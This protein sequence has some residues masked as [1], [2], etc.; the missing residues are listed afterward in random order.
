MVTRKGESQPTVWQEKREASYEALVRSAMRCFYERGYTL[1]RVEDIVGSTGYTSGAFYFHFKNKADCFWHV[2]DYRQRRRRGWDAF[3]DGIDPSSV[4][5]Q[6][7]LSRAQAG[8]A[9][10]EGLSGWTIVMVEHFQ[11][12]REDPR[13]AER[14]A[15]LF[16]GWQRTQTAFVQRLQ[17]RGWVHPS[18]DAKMVALQLL[19]FVEGLAVHSIVFGIEPKAARAA[20]VDGTARLLQAG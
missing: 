14:F 18:R 4:S 6:E 8:L 5:L 19:S 1:T 17:D 10:D 12:H 7:V 20:L 11:Q 16:R 9:P 2:I 15:E 13:V 3:L